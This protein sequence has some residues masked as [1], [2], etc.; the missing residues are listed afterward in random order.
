[1][2]HPDTDL[3]QSL[4]PGKAHLREALLLHEEALRINRCNEEKVEEVEKKKEKKKK[5]K[6]EN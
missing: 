2:F 4:S 3:V 5:K 6:K 1:M